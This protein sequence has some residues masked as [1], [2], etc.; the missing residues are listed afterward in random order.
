MILLELFKRLPFCYS[1]GDDGN[2]D[3]DGNDE[4][5]GNCDDGN[6]NNDDD[7]DYDYD[8]YGDYYYDN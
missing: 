7:Y 6:D 8:V 2:D 4:N 1:F 5:D 3:D